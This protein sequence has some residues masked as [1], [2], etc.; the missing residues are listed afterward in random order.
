MAKTRKRRTTAKPLPQS[1]MVTN[2]NGS[3]S[4]FVKVACH[5]TK[6]AAKATQKTKHNAGRRA[7][8]LKDPVTGKHCAFEGPKKKAAVAKKSTGRKRGRPASK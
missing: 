3:K 2:A 6:T 4:R 8:V 1:M 7:I 5:D